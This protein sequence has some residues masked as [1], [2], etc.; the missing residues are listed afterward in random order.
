MMLHRFLNSLSVSI[1][2][3]FLVSASAEE[4]ENPGEALNKLQSQFAGARDL[5]I[6]PIHKLNRNYKS[7][8]ERLLDSEAAAGR[9]ESSV[10]VRAEIEAF[11]DGSEFSQRDFEK[12]T[13]SS[14]ALVRL[15]EIYTEQRAAAE[16][17]LEGPRKELIAKYTDHLE[18]FE[19]T[20]TR[21]KNLDV[22]LEARGIRESLLAERELEDG[23][24]V[25][26][27]FAAKGEAEFRYGGSE[28]S[29]RTRKSDEHYTNGESSEFKVEPGSV[30]TL[31][32]RGSAGFRGLIMALE[33][34]DGKVSIPIPRSAYKVTPEEMYRAEPTAEQIDK[35][36]EFPESGSPDPKMGP[37]WDGTDLS[38]A[39]RHA[40]Q[41][42][43][44][45]S[46]EDWNY[47][48]IVIE[49]SMIQRRK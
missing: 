33:S 49:D 11:G 40:S 46:Q 26:L 42:I 34:E 16:K 10:E 32:F 6:E 38:E 19:K 5:L 48:A 7:A 17:N 20:Q 1:A 14:E 44:P 9:L 47:F 22:A 18:E 45:R 41:W 43:K 37:L 13:Y 39:T 27:V 15:R 8:L 23:Y 28:V 25:R 30:L 3:F 35:L 4:T 2:A 31:R 12:R 21:L 29:V 36:E 24:G